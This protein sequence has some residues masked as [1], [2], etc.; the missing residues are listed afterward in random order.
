MTIKGSFQ[1]SIAIVRAFFTQ[2]ILSP[3]KMCQTITFWRH[4]GSK[5][6]ILFTGPLK[7][8]SLHKMT[9]LILVVKIDAG[10]V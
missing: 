10:E 6:N 3:V 1:V 7:G 2:N 8:S 9:S 4:I 5:Y